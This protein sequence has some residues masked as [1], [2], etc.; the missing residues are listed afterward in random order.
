MAGQVCILCPKVAQW[1]VSAVA[2]TGC[3]ALCADCGVLCYLMQPRVC[4]TVPARIVRNATRT[5]FPVVPGQLC[6]FRC[7][8]DARK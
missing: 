2:L 3:R 5:G 1:C 7:R 4:E 8:Q 6:C